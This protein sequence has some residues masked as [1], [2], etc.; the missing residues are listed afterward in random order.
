[1]TNEI[2][3]DSAIDLI[4]EKFNF[5]PTRIV[6]KTLTLK[7][8]LKALFNR[9]IPTFASSMVKNREAIFKFIPSGS[10]LLKYLLEQINYKVC[11]NCLRILSL[12][13]FPENVGKLYS[14]CKECKQKK[15]K[16][17]YEQNKSDY[18]AKDANRRAQKLHATPKWA[19]LEQIKQFYKNKP[20]GYHVDHIIPL[21]S[22]LV[23]GLHVLENLQYLPATENLK[24]S[25]KFEV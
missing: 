7:E 4:I 6:Y 19:Q 22:K 1:M 13:S 10:N 21:Q 8:F 20:E 11:S 24:K 3:L 5:P 17:H 14:Q 16:L 12:N 15:S 18:F 25:N 2:A 23:C 9:S